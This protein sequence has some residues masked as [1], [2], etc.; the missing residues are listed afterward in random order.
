MTVPNLIS[1]L[2]MLLVPL[3]IWLMLSNSFMAAFYVFIAAGI[4]DGVDGYLARRFN[5]QTELGAYLDAIADKSLLVSIYIVLGVLTII[6]L[7]LVIIVVTRDILIVGGVMLSRVLN[8][9]VR[10][11]PLW[12][13][14]VNT[15]GQIVFAGLL[16]LMLGIGYGVQHLLVPGAAIVAFLTLASGALYARDWF[17]HMSGSG[18]KL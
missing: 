11:K 8:T 1:L 2:R 4:S 17:R 16:L 12:I 14:K 3:A 13:S 7:W 9:P 15:V 10:V 5:W 18:V 6:P